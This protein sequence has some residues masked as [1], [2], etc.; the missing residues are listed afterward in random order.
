MKSHTV[1]A[2]R[3][4]PDFSYISFDKAYKLAENLVKVDG[5]A[6]MKEFCELIGR[7]KTGWLGLEVKSMR[8]WGLIS[9]KGKMNLTEKFYKISS[10]KDPHEKL[11]IKREAFMNISLFKQIFEKYFNTRLPK[12]PELSIF[13]ESEYNINPTYSSY[14]AKIILDSIQ[15]YF[16]EYGKN[17]VKSNENS[18]KKETETSLNNFFGK[19]NSI[20][21]KIESPIGNFNLEATNKEEFGKILK[22]INALWDE[23]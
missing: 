10:S 8:V 6:T 9:G 19:K 12:K 4:I 1:N 21:I 23:K 22:I 18:L 20:H 2:V 16:R 17:Y 15:M 3:G 13:L 7:K 11:M 5:S 14:V